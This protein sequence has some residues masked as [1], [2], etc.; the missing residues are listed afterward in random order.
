MPISIPASTN[1]EE[2]EAPHVTL[3]KLVRNVYGAGS[4]EYAIV[5]KTVGQTDGVTAV[6]PTKEE[7]EAVMKVV[8]GLPPEHR[9]EATSLVGVAGL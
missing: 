3:L 1:L 8:S 5:V 7:K 6:L 9:T 4:P 2:H